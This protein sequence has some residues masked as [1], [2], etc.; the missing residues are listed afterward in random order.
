MAS[1]SVEILV[2]VLPSDGLP[3]QNFKFRT[4]FDP[5]HRWPEFRLAQAPQLARGPDAIFQRFEIIEF[6][7]NPDGSEPCSGGLGHGAF[8]RVEQ[9]LSR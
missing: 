8:E 4:W 7:S 6:V 2:V 9:K 5:L 3:E 1:F